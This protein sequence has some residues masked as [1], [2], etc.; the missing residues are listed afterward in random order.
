MSRKREVTSW[1]DLLQKAKKD[2]ETLGD[3]MK[4]M[5]ARWAGPIK[6]GADREFVKVDGPQAPPKK[7]SSRKKKSSS[8]KKGKPR[9]T[10]R[11]RAHSEP[12]PA[13]VGHVLRH[14]MQ[15]IAVHPHL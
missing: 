11:K 13:P 15:L 12:A 1:S 2:G 5:K 3:T 4:R 6:S 14:L 9:R 8:G 10:T 7:R